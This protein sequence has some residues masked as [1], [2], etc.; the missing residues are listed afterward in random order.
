[1]ARKND[2][3]GL[4]SLIRAHPSHKATDGRMTGNNRLCGDQ[5]TIPKIDINCVG[6]SDNSKVL[7][8]F[9][10]KEQIRVMQRHS[11]P[12]VGVPPVTVRDHVR[13]VSNHF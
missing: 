5:P 2:H 10:F 13:F 11:I 9:K 4:W 8:E 12:Q 3:H 6:V 1:M 7:I